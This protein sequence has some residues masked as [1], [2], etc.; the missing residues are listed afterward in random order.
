MKCTLCLI[1]EIIDNTI[2][3]FLQWFLH[4]YILIQTAACMPHRR[5]LINGS[6]FL[7]K[8]TKSSALQVPQLFGITVRWKSNFC[9][10]TIIRYLY[11]FVE[12]FDDTQT[13]TL[14][15]PGHNT[16]DQTTPQRSLMAMLTSVV[17]TKGMTAYIFST[18][19]NGRHF[20][21]AIYADA[22][23]IMK[24]LVF[25]FKFHRSLL[26]EVQLTITQHW[27]R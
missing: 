3:H 25:W 13:L 9:I 21:D 7:N 12:L 22:F 20:A 5:G 26:L 24:S 10:H 11:V 19:Q 4:Q 27:F 17:L 16:P 8:V 6:L 2:G 23:S 18:G 1:L 14:Y 15:P